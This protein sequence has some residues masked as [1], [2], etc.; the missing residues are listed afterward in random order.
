MNEG[1]GGSENDRKREKRTGTILNT[2]QHTWLDGKIETVGKGFIF[3]L[4]TQTGKNSAEFSYLIRQKVK[5][6]RQRLRGGEAKGKRGV[7]NTQRAWL[8]LPHLL[9]NL[10]EE[11]YTHRLHI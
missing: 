1:E 10:W 7:G 3:L 8:L 4:N 9:I 2:Q 11:P 6:P 5:I